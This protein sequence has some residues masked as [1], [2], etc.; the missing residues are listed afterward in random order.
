MQA[1]DSPERDPA[2]PRKVTAQRVNT[3]RANLARSAETAPSDTAAAALDIRRQCHITL[4]LTGT[5]HGPRS[6]LLL[7]RVRVERPVRAFAAHLSALLG[8]LPAAGLPP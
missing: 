6:G 7:L 4:K 5:Q 1:R 2:T 3:M 8:E